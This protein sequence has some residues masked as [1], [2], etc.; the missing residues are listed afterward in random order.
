MSNYVKM[1][2]EQPSSI[3]MDLVAEVRWSKGERLGYKMDY[4]PGTGTSVDVRV[5]NPRKPVPAVNV[6]KFLYLK[7]TKQP[8]P[9]KIRSSTVFR[10]ACIE[11]RGNGGSLI[12]S[13]RC[14]SNEVAEQEYNRLIKFIQPAELVLDDEVRD[15]T[16][17]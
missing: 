17:R 1:N 10:K 6:F 12:L 9:W 8:I 7:F 3:N 4:L 11:L 13:I 5:N 14:P 15:E 2:T 16:V